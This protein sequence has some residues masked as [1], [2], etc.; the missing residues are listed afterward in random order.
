MAELSRVVIAGAGIA[1]LTTAIALQQ[2]GV[3]TVVLERRDSPGRLLTGGGFMLWHNAFLALRE[4]KMDEAVAAVG[5]EI[6]VH[7]FRTDRGRRLAAW[8]VGEAARRL[9][10]PAVALRRSALNTVLMEAA[11]E[12]VRMAAPCVGYDQDADGVTV[13]LADGTVERADLLVGADGLRSTVRDQLRRGHDLPPRYAG[14]TAWQAITRLPGED[15]VRS[16]TFYNLWGRG[17]LR[18]LYCR[19]NAE[20]V[21]WDAITCDHVSGSFDTVRQTKRD[22]MAHAYRHWPDPVPRLIEGT[23]EDAILPIDIVDRPP[24]R[25]GAWGLGRVVLVGDAAHPMTLNLSQGAGQAIEDAVVLT[26]LLGE[27]AG[28]PEAIE[29]FEQ[30]RRERAMAMVRT[31]WN[32]GVMG[33]WRDGVRSTLRDW[34]MRAFFG[35]VGLRQSYD[36]MMNVSFQHAGDR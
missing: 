14:Y 11:G 7:E 28:I 6:D 23:D 35:S 13:R 29:R 36:L 19:L 34:F 33:R 1:G 17:G 25:A 3:E 22:V 4:I 16:G 5:Q 31:S 26:A 10:A 12:C 32:I 8:P 24:G 18:F 9:G 15:V 27:C 2:A 21:Y 20:E 30:A